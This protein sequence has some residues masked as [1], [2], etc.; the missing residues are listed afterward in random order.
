MPFCKKGYRWQKN[1]DTVHGWNAAGIENRYFMASLSHYG[2]F[3]EIPSWFNGDFS[4]LHLPRRSQTCSTKRFH[5]RKNNVSSN[6]FPVISY[7][8][9]PTRSGHGITN[10]NFMH[11]F[12]PTKFPPNDVCNI[13]IKFDPTKNGWH[14]MTLTTQPPPQFLPLQKSHRSFHQNLHPTCF[15]SSFRQICLPRCHRLTALFKG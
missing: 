4:D 10:P 14:L 7:S 12:C 11:Y 5:R 8:W 15:D 3:Q 1:N 13:C 6:F 9:F 2:G